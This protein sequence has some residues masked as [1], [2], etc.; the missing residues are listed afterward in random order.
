M[1]TRLFLCSWSGSSLEECYKRRVSRTFFTFDF[2]K[3]SG[4]TL[5][6]HEF[7]FASTRHMKDRS[8]RSL[9]INAYLGSFPVFYVDTILWWFCNGY[10]LN[11]RIHGHSFPDQL[12]KPSTSSRVCIT[13]SNS[14]NPSRVYRRKTFSILLNICIHVPRFDFICVPICHPRYRREFLDPVPNR[15]GAFTRSDLVLPSQGKWPLSK[16]TCSLL[17]WSEVTF[18]SWN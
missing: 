8:P 7:I 2:V 18:Q 15:S 5:P 14:P 11:Y 9:S 1:W 3:M 13:V 12:C 4:K 16:I 10:W 6:G 17:I